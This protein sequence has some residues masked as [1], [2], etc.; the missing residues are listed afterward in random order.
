MNRSRWAREGAFFRGW[1]GEVLGEFQVVVDDDT[2]ESNRD[3]GPGG[4]LAVGI[5]CG[6]GEIDVVG[7]PSERR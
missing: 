7:L 3:P 5:E 1:G 2:I 4:S 6:G